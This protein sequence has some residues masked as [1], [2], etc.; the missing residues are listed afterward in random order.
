M[1]ENLL[2]SYT[3]KGTPAAVFLR[4]DLFRPSFIRSGL[5]E[6]GF[7]RNFDDHFLIE[8]LSAKNISVPVISRRDMPQI[9]PIAPTA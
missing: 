1:A 5:P 9:F 8:S 4:G 7:E 2:K 3:R 6:T